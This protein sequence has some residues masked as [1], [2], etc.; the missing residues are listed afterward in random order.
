VGSSG[1]NLFIRGVKKWWKKR[2]L[3][4]PNHI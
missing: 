1:I 4:E 2:N 3:N